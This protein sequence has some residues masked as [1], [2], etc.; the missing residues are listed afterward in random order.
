[1]SG[2]YWSLNDFLDK[3]KHH[4]SSNHK[5]EGT[6]KEKKKINHN[7]HQKKD[8][9]ILTEKY[10][11]NISSPKEFK[12]QAST[13]DHQHILF[14]G[15]RQ[16]GGGN[17]DEGRKVTHR[18]PKSHRELFDKQEKV[19]NTSDIKHRKEVDTKG[20]NKADQKTHTKSHKSS[21]RHHHHHHHHKDSHRHYRKD[22]HRHN[23]RESHRQHHNK[24]EVVKKESTSGGLLWNCVKSVCSSFASVVKKNIFT[25]DNNRDENSRSKII[26]EHSRLIDKKGKKNKLKDTSQDEPSVSIISK[27]NFEFE[28]NKNEYDNSPKSSNKEMEKS[29]FKNEKKIP[30]QGKNKYKQDD[31]TISNRNKKIK[32]STYDFSENDIKNLFTLDNDEKGGEGYHPHADTKLMKNHDDH[33]DSYHMNVQD[34]SNKISNWDGINENEGDMN[35]SSAKLLLSNMSNSHV[36]SKMIKKHGGGVSNIQRENGML[37]GPIPIHTATI[38]N[39]CYHHQQEQEKQHNK[40]K[41]D[42]NSK[43]WKMIARSSDEEQ[44]HEWKK[45]LKPDDNLRNKE[46]SKRNGIHKRSS[47]TND[48]SSYR[49]E[50]EAV[51]NNQHMKNSLLKLFLQMGEHSI[52]EEVEEATEEEEEKVVEKEEVETERNAQESKKMTVSNTSPRS[53]RSKTNAHEKSG[54]VTYEEKQFLNRKG[55]GKELDDISRHNENVEKLYYEQI[56]EDC[57]KKD[58]SLNNPEDS[59]ADSFKNIFYERTKKGKMVNTPCNYRVGEENLDEQCQAE[60]GKIEEMEEMEKTESMEE[61]ES[62]NNNKINNSMGEEASAKAEGAPS[63]DIDETEQDDVHEGKKRAEYFRSFIKNNEEIKQIR[64]EYKQL[65]QTI[66]SFIYENSNENEIISSSR[67]L[68]N[69]HGKSLIQ[70]THKRE[71]KN[72][73]AYYEMT[74]KQNTINGNDEYM[75]IIDDLSL[76]DKSGYI[77]LKNDE[78]S[79]I[80]A[81]ERLRIDKKKMEKEKEA[82]KME[83][84]IETKKIEEKGKTE[85]K[86]DENK[87]IGKMDKSIFFKCN[88][89]NHY[90]MAVKI[91]NQ[92]GENNVLI[93]KFNVP[94]L[95]SQIKCLTDTRWLNDEV[96][97]F[98]MSMLQEY[99]EQNTRNAMVNN[100]PKIFTFS[101][102]FFQSLSSN[103]TYNYNKVS[104]WTKRKKVDIFSF[105][106]ILI[107][108]HIGGNHWTLGSINIKEKKIKLYDSLNM[109]N[110]KFFEYMKRYIV[111]E[112]R[113]KKQKELDVSAWEYNKDGRSE[114]GIPYQENGYDCGVFTCMFAKCLSFNRNFDFS[115]RDI[116]EIRM[117]MVYEISQGCLV[118]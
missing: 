100:L 111:D 20:D 74:D 50:K 30:E 18:D 41:E 6:Y 23:R 22:T 29:Y 80:Q 77:I 103:G 83:E 11:K 52:D 81:L 76:E 117:K 98:Y 2:G 31:E 113:D 37:E 79:L 66:D 102:F 13:N 70:N 104:R 108:L 53:S 10:N 93:D 27:N 42:M 64:Y 69:R 67:L 7:V 116:K 107:P 46:E 25:Y 40:K 96:I 33:I 59:C 90:E 12:I 39:R 24:K 68:H 94:L 15:Y 112:M 38:S 26:S 97:N 88:K 72:E 48:S 57:N 60:N 16:G 44:T 85:E 75:K 62:K 4:K 105:D 56:F 115:Q 78:E 8:S 43:G 34:V 110:K 89:K 45:N 95:Y 1:M 9:Y 92:K 114:A 47:F 106:L 99:N 51:H 19:L 101:T 17:H 28:K 82:K 36:S 54:Y 73:S 86:E 14:K 5:F 58:K 109:P 71:S 32:N 87:K 84:E 55:K 49:G 3:D 63:V 61:V 118:F 91:L 35:S 21:H 65:I